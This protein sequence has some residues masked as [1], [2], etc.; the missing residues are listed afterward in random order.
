MEVKNIYTEL[1]NFA[2]NKYDDIADEIQDN[3]AY[4][5][6]DKKYDNVSNVIKSK[7]SI[8]NDLVRQAL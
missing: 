5:Y 6:A 3:K 1:T 8:A 7:M 4:K 2:K